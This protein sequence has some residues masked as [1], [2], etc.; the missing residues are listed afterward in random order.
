V[1]V[2]V[3]VFVCVCVC[4]CVF[5]CLCVCVC[6]CVDVVCVCVYAQPASVA[7]LQAQV[8]QQQIVQ[9]QQQ[10]LAATKCDRVRAYAYVHAHHVHSMQKSARVVAALLRNYRALVGAGVLGDGG[11]VID[12]VVRRDGEIDVH[13]AA[14]TRNGSGSATALAMPNAMLL[15]PPASSIAPS[16]LA[17]SAV[18]TPSGSPTSTLARS[19]SALGTASRSQPADSQ[20]STTTSGT[21]TASV[22][23]AVRTPSARSGPKLPPKDG[24]CAVCCWVVRAGCD[25]ICSGLECEERLEF[26]DIIDVID[27]VH[28]CDERIG[29]A[30]SLDVCARAACTDGRR[31]AAGR[32]LAAR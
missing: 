9:Q 4:V 13:A 21:T 14:R 8:A 24:A 31:A 1:C 23:S 30:E 7:A 2:C 28:T 27:D 25:R 3:C 22:P 19:D 18:I 5:V 26:V 6:A 20:P 17:R 29:D 11:A 16:S 10:L 12:D 15:A 32:D